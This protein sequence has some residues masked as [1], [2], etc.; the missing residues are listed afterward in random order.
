MA[1]DS[2]KSNLEETIREMLYIHS[3]DRRRRCQEESGD[4]GIPRSNPHRRKGLPKYGIGRAEV[5]LVAICVIF[6]VALA[7]SGI[8]Q[9]RLSS[10]ENYCAGRQFRVALAIQSFDAEFQQLPGYRELQAIDAQDQPVGCSWVFPILPFLQPLDQPLTIRG[11]SSMRTDKGAAPVELS[12][13]EEIVLETTTFQEIV[14]QY[15]PAGPAELRGGKPKMRIPELICPGDL[16]GLSLINLLSWRVNS[17]LPDRPTGKLPADW[18]ANGVFV[19]QFVPEGPVEELTLGSIEAADGKNY[20]V[21]FS[22][23]LRVDGLDSLDWT[24]SE[25]AAVGIVWGFGPDA[26]EPAG[27]QDLAAS[28]VTGE[29]WQLNGLEPELGTSLPGPLGRRPTSVHQKG[30]N[31]TFCSGATSLIGQT[32]IRL[33]GHK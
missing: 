17:G 1:W 18:T 8:Y 14:D 12:S 21:L 15:G 7:A 31:V 22:E 29:S 25:E 27:A 3:T 19:N 28:S 20:T 30:I 9:R 33:R 10:R 6:V 23:G 5:V 4:P 26:D 13:D 32:S 24:Q 2:R 16:E 11:S